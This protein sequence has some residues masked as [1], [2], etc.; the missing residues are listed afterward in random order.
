MEAQAPR[1]AGSSAT[2]P[3]A[4]LAD[5][6]GRIDEHVGALL[7][8]PDDERLDARWARALQAARDLALRP[9]KRLRPALLLVGWALA[10]DEEP[11]PEGVWRFAAALEVLHTFLLIHDDVAD[12]AAIRRGGPTLHRSFAGP[13]AADLAVIVGDHLFARAIDGMLETDLP[14]VAAAVRYYLGVCRSTAAGQ[15]LDV[16]LSGAALGDVTLFQTL[17][18]A[19]L[20]TARYGFAAPLVVGGRLGGAGERLLGALERT[21]RQIGLAFQLRD[22]LLGL[23]GAPATTGKPT[24]DWVGRK[25]T[26]P[27]VAAYTRAPAAVRRELDALWSGAADHP[28]ALARARDLLEA[29]GGRAAAEHAVERATRSAR[30]S[31]LALPGPAAPRGLLDAL[32][33]ALAAR[34]S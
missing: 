18:V 25:P 14:G 29:H 11:A 19:V 7:T 17:K 34:T 13:H 23:F 10:R 21:G 4:W 2:S 5:V 20:K 24:G 27:I 30:R 32:V 12:R 15:F 16:E 6:R 9:A 8:M 28:A 33:R 22:D 31:V 26:F 1:G 3:E